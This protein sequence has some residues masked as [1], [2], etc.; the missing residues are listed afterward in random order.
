[1]V[2]VVVMGPSKCTLS[3]RVSPSSFVFTSLGSFGITLEGMAKGLWRL[4][5]I[6]RNGGGGGA[7]GG[8]SGRLCDGAIMGLSIRWSSPLVRDSK[9]PSDKSGGIKGVLVTPGVTIGRSCMR[10]G[11]FGMVNVS[12]LRRSNN[13]GGWNATLE[14][15]PGGGTSRHD[16]VGGGSDVGAP[17]GG[18]GSGGSS[19]NSDGCGDSDT[20]GDLPAAPTRFKERFFMF[21]LRPD[22]NASD[23]R[24]CRGETSRKMGSDAAFLG[25]V[26]GL[27]PLETAAVC[28]AATVVGEWRPTILQVLLWCRGAVSVY[29]FRAVVLHFRAFFFFLGRWGRDWMAG[30]CNKARCL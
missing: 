19:S 23:W 8:S 1:M 27:C 26:N 4:G 21:M 25:E 6:A 22:A 13:G 24:A 16:A 12:V 9:R 20:P 11:C 3:H 7:G 2:V 30:C 15:P 18:S 17:A 14:S 5:G 28:V 29:T 10:S